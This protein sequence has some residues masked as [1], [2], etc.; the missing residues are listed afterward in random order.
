MGVIHSVSLLCPPEYTPCSILI[1]LSICFLFFFGIFSWTPR[2]WFFKE[3]FVG[4]FFPQI[5]HKHGFFFSWT[6]LICTLKL[7]G[8]VNVTLQIWQ[9]TVSFFS[10]TVKRQNFSKRIKN[11]YQIQI[12][13]FSYN[14]LSTH[15]AVQVSKVHLKY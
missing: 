14:W 13:L 7:A 1:V 11:A 3:A 12:I 4:R 2:M 9:E 15:S 8:T 6:V 10:C 5:L